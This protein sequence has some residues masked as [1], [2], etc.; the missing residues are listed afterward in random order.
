M[1]R[2]L[3][4]CSFFS[5]TQYGFIAGRGTQCLLE[6]RSDLLD[7]TFEQNQYACGLVLDVPKAFDSLSHN[8]HLTKLFN[9][10]FP[11]PLLTLLTNV[12]TEKS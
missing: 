6:E 1:T 8:I 3:K 11:G 9:A 12:L 4:K 10:G 5:P 7:T 2:F